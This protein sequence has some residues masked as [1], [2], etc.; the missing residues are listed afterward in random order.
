LLQWHELFTERD[1]EQK[2]QIEEAKRK[3]RR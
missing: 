1:A 3:A 2:K